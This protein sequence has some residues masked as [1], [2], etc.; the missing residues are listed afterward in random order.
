MSRRSFAPAASLVAAFVLMAGVF[1]S[2]AAQDATPAASS[3]A[4][5]P[6]HIH[7]GTCETLGDVVFPLADVALA[8]A[9][10]EAVASP[11]ADGLGGAV[12]ESTTTVDIALE[13]I[14][15]AEHAINVHESVENIGNYIACGDVTGEPVD[16]S[17]KV[18]LAELNGSGFSG[19]V[20]LA[21][22]GDGTTT[23]T[24]TLAGG[25]VA[26][27]AAETG[28]MDVVEVEISGLAF[29][30]NTV[31]IPAGGSVTWT[32]NDPEPHTA[33]GQDRDVLQSGTLQQGESFTQTFDTAGTYEYFCEFHAGMNGTVI[34]E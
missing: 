3:T 14:L 12:A 20:T 15:A 2:A 13:D 31:T 21:D 11:A 23:V 32:N 1:A 19:Q 24:I 18:D 8:P 27:P 9:T 29:S 28:S 22:N 6:A 10:A 26:T 4:A 30:P 33:T 16:G 25:D 7:S 17:L 34:V 5:H